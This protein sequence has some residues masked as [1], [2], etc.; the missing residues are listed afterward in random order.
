MKRNLLITILCVAIAVA[1][2]IF[3]VRNIRHRQQPGYRELIR[4]SIRISEEKSQLHHDSAQY[5]ND[6]H[7]IYTAKSDSVRN[8]D[9]A[10]RAALRE[11][12]RARLRAEIRASA[13]R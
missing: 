4:D 12:Y 11:A 13:T 8:L 1:A 7:K 10:G 3:F 2:T 9:S 5:W 6:Q